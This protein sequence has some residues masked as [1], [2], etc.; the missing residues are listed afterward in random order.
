MAASIRGVLALLAA[1]GCI[2]L[3]GVCAR[4]V[5]P[6]LG[7]ASQNAIRFAGAAAILCCA[8]MVSGLSFRLK[9]KAALHTFLLAATTAFLAVAFAI[10]VQHIPLGQSVSL[11]YGASIVSGS[12]ISA[13]VL[14][15]RLTVGRGVAVVIALIG[16]TV[17]IGPTVAIGI[18]TATALLAGGLDAI[19]HTLRVRLRGNDARTVAL[20]S[21]VAAAPLA[22]AVATGGGERISSA[23][24]TTGVWL[25]IAIYVAATAALAPLLLIGFRHVDLGPGTVLLAT[26][27]GFALLLGAVFLNE[28][29]TARALVA[30]VLIFLGS[31]YS[32]I[33][34]YFAKQR[35]KSNV[36]QRT[37][38]AS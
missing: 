2:A 6:A 26:Q 20:W 37:T 16:L 29:V 10:S 11:L 36:E 5:S 4:L 7:V 24:L 25:G 23:E 15:Q 21:Y 8:V 35:E 22:V 27:V 28:P 17:Y 34:I 14:R 13:A 31:T 30:S 9:G 38:G 33:D 19:T 12:L 3:F 32:L 18:G 1:A